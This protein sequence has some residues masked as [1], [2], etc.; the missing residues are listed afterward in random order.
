MGLKQWQTGRIVALWI[1][2]PFTM[3]VLFLVTAMLSDALG[4]TTLA[5]ISTPY[6]LLWTVMS[7][8]PFVTMLLV[9]WRWLKLQK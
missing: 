8:F 9:T 6:L 5:E 2:T 3:A 4:W 7:F 1:A